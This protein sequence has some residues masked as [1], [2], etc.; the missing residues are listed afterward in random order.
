MSEDES[1]KDVVEPHLSHLVSRVS[2]DPH[3]WLR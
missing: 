1:L 2:G 3:L